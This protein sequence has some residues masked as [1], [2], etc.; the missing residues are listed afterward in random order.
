MA[1][2]S[3]LMAH[4][5]LLK[6]Q[7]SKSQKKKQQFPKTPT[8][9]HQKTHNHTPQLGMGPRGSTPKPDFAPIFGV[10]FDV[11]GCLG[12]SEKNCNNSI[13]TRT[14]LPIERYF[15][16]RNIRSVQKYNKSGSKSYQSGHR[17]RIIGELT[18]ADSSVTRDP[19]T[20]LS[21]N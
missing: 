19:S 6:A 12:R 20:G 8:P 10:L 16:L 4:S 15:R 7:S 14:F 9:H 2:C 5:S 21:D 3:R 13:N 1:Q 17:G 18:W 11:R